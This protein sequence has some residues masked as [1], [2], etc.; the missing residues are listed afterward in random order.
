MSRLAAC[1]ASWRMVSPRPLAWTSWPRCFETILRRGAI[2]FSGCHCTRNFAVA[3]PDHM[4]NEW[5]ATPTGCLPATAG[6]S[7]WGR[8]VPPG[9]AG[10]DRLATQDRVK[11]C[12]VAAGRSPACILSCI[13]ERS[14]SW[15][16]VWR[17]SCPWPGQSPTCCSPRPARG[18][19]APVRPLQVVR[20]PP[21]PH[22]ACP[23]LH[24]GPIR[25]RPPPEWLRRPR[26][27][28]S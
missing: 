13:V 17:Y 10:Q 5:P 4:A 9:K 1:S 15:R 24:T 23:V 12:A 11:G 16:S 7:L 25:A 22:G 21:T 27:W 3:M 20:R 28:R 14:L 6:A 18:N 2:I 26:P 8:P 19:G